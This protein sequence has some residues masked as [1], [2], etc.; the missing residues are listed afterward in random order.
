MS[1]FCRWVR[2]RLSICLWLVDT[3]LTTRAPFL[4]KIPKP[5]FL[6][7]AINALITA[8]KDPLKI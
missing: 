8:L 6:K 3:S 7:E 2:F 4:K 1:V 5:N